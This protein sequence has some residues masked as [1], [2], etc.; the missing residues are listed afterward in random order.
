MIM[1]IAMARWLSRSA[2]GEYQRMAGRWLATSAP[3]MLSSPKRFA[4]ATMSA[5][6]LRYPQPGALGRAGAEDRQSER[7]SLR[8][9]P[10]SH[11]AVALVGMMPVPVGIND[12]VDEV[13]CA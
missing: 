12:V 1:T 2:A 6:R 10:G 5:P 3:S 4:V 13:D 9:L 7:M 11:R 8:E